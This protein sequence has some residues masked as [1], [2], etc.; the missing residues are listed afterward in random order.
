L[1][2]QHFYFIQKFSAVFATNSLLELGDDECGNL[3][4]MSFRID[5]F[6][7]RKNSKF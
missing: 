7:I 2:S 6:K 5:S 1:T 3:N 4:F